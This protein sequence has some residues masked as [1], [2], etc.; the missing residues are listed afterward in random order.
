[1]KHQI[2][3]YGNTCPDR[4]KCALYA[5]EAEVDK[6]E[7]DEK[8]GK[9]CE[10]FQ[11][12]DGKTI[13]IKRATLMGILEFTGDFFEH[14]GY[15]YCI[16]WVDGSMSAIELSTGFRAANIDDSTPLSNVPEAKYIEMVKSM[17]A[18]RSILM[19]EGIK[20]ARKTMREF[21]IPYPLNEMIEVLKG[22]GK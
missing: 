7:P 21:N 11:G 17:V 2:K 12:K 9:K 4:F 5:T 13:K 15:Q 1:M 22:G 10:F 19:D 3:C 18:E 6:T 20:R 16:G 8:P 14:E